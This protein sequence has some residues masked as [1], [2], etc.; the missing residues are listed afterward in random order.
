MADW[1]RERGGGRV[2]R[3]EREPGDEGGKG[4]WADYGRSPS[5]DF[6]GEGYREGYRTGWTPATWSGASATGYGGEYGGREMEEPATG[7]YDPRGIEP[8]ERERQGRGLWNR[9]KRGLHIG[10]GPKGYK[11]S[12]D[13]INEDV[14]DMLERDPDVDASEIEVVVV[15]GEV[16]LSGSVDDRWAKRRAEDVIADLPGVKDVHN[17]LRVAPGAGDTSGAPSRATSSPSEITAEMP[18]PDRTSA[19]PSTPSTT[20]RSR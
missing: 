8:A 18:A 16:T 5:R 11:R 17:R 7:G 9:V 6:A 19:R 3:R 14:C 4:S 13:R 12:D 1:D 20:K 2:P 15:S 10:K